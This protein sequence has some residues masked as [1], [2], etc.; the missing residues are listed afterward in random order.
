MSLQ[1][2][3][4]DVQYRHPCCFKA[5]LNTSAVDLAISLIS[6]LFVEKFLSFQITTA[7]ANNKS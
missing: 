1:T 3:G 5:C 4:T 7:S 6:A 2:L